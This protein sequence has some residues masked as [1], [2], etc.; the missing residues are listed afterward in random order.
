MVIQLLTHPAPTS[1][2]GSPKSRPLRVVRLP[3]EPAVSLVM[4]GATK[5]AWKTGSTRANK[6]LFLKNQI[7]KRV[8]AVLPPVYAPLILKRLKIQSFLIKMR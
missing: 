4:S 7:M 3:P 1:R 8:T 5:R 2:T 6:K